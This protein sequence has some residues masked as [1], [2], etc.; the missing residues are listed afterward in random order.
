MKSIGTMVKRIEGLVGTSDVTEW[1]N[2]FIESV[3]EKTD[4]GNN[5]SRLTEKQL[6]VI[7]RIHN[8]HFAG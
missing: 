5:T 8:K 4:C 2:N 7:Q 3:V 1:E 6:E